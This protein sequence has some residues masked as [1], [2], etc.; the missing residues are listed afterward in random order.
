M[1]SHDTNYQAPQ[2][3]PSQMSSFEERVQARMATIRF[4]KEQD[5]IEIEARRRLNIEKIQGKLARQFAAKE[6]A[7]VDA[8][9]KEKRIKIMGVK[10]RIKRIERDID[11]EVNLYKRIHSYTE[12][13]PIEV[14]PYFNNILCDVKKTHSENTSLLAV[15]TQLLQQL[16]N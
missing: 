1:L 12:F 4:Q 8:A 13:I 5:A 14:I 7:I 11:I 15:K 16:T 6:Q 9:E 3:Y 10:A 2:A